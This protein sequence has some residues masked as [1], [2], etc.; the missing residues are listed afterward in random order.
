MWFRYSPENVSEI[1][2][3]AQEPECGTG[4]GKNDMIVVYHPRIISCPPPEEGLAELD[5]RH[6]EQAD[7]YD[8]REPDCRKCHRAKHALEERHINGEQHE[9][10]ADSDA[11][12]EVGIRKEVVPENTFVE[13]AERKCEEE[14]VA[15]EARED[16]CLHE[17]HREARVEQYPIQAEEE[18]TRRESHKKN[19][20]TH[21]GVE[22][23]AA[24]ARS[25]CERAVPFLKREGNRRKTVG[26]KIDIENLKR[27][28]WK[29][30][31]KKK[32]AAD[33]K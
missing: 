5:S 13:I 23:R 27:I 32:R 28:E 31:A 8:T 26:E 4:H 1:E 18:S 29:R 14:R 19:E 33:E 21:Y 12:D 17:R 25:A 22:E 6:V 15:P 20:E 2:N 7:E 30:H 10:D 3:E 24:R 11:A 16:K 9:R